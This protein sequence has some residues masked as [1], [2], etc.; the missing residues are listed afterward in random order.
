MR[1]A[2]CDDEIRCVQA[3][4]QAIERWSKARELSMIEITCFTSSEDLLENWRRRP[5]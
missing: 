2:I 5:L 1:I 4:R 3:L